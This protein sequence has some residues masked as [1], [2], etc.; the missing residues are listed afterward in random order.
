MHA[1]GP[2][3]TGQVETKVLLTMFNVS[4]LLVLNSFIKNLLMT[5]S[6]ACKLDLVKGQAS[7]PYKRTGRHLLLIKRR[8]TWSKSHLIVMRVMYYRMCWVLQ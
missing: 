1:F 4:I 6:K 8:V 3:N 5:K 2:Q 7:R